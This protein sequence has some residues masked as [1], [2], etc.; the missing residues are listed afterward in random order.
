MT[1][2]A[3]KPVSSTRPDVRVGV[4][5]WN[6]AA[7]LDRCLVSLP[8]ALG[9]LDAEVVVVDN[10]S[11]DSSAEIAERH[12]D[13]RVVRNPTNVGYARAMNTALAGTAAPVLAAVNPDTVI[14]PGALA[15]LVG[16]LMAARPGVG[17]VAP[18]LANLDGGTQ[19][20]AYRFPSPAVSLATALP[21]WA[22]RGRLGRRLGLEA[23]GPSLT[24]TDVDWTI[25]AIHVVLAEALGGRRPYD[26]RWFM[27]GE[28]IELCWW[29]AQRG[30]RRRYEADV[31]VV[32]EGNVAGA[33]AWGGRRT[34]R[35]LA[36]TYDWYGRDRGRSAA[37]RWATANTAACAAVAVRLAVTGHGREAVSLARLA[38]VHARAIARLPIPDPSVPA[39]PATAAGAQRPDAVP[40]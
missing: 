30:W 17:L 38:G 29:L 23:A 7:E 36:T 15:T 11:G 13:V 5:S 39:V 8:E 10:A 12:R 33:K 21:V 1:G 27:Y 3:S 28:D 32:H 9:S 20:S 24:A 2:D 37:R 18:R 40:T 19:H 14:P 4:V 35:W 22:Q 16:R 26:E 25:G 31:V 6:T 34:E